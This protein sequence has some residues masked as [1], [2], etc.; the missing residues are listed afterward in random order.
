MDDEMIAQIFPSVMQ[1][2]QLTRRPSRNPRYRSRHPGE[3]YD[4]ELGMFSQGAGGG[5]P[6]MAGYIPGV[7]G[8]RMVGTGGVPGYGGMTTQKMFS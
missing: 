2:S 5:L 7:S 1:S 4:D 3:I 6:F 8:M